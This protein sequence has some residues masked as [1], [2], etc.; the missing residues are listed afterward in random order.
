MYIE[1]TNSAS[2][3]TNNAKIKWTCILALN[4]CFISPFFFPC[5]IHIKRC[6][7]MDKEAEKKENNPIIPPTTL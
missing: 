5:S 2:T 7:E 3:K 1:P 6:V 4:I